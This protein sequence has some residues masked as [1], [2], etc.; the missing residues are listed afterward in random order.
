MRSSSV[1]CPLI[2]FDALPPQMTKPPM[3]AHRRSI[4][5]AETSCPYHG[6]HWFPP[7]KRS[8][9][10]NVRN[11]V[12]ITTFNYFLLKPKVTLSIFV[13]DITLDRSTTLARIVYHVRRS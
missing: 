6:K 7:P 8:Q 13:R 2:W 4:T 10:Y 9:L 3:L 12:L 1:A 5:F 11:W